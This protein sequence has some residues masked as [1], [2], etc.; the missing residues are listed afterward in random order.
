M[1][2]PLLE[3]KVVN[4]LKTPYYD[5]YIGRPSEWGNDH[6]IGWCKI[7]THS[8]DRNGAIMAFKR[9]FLFKL[10]NARFKLSLAELRGK[11]L[12]CHCAPLGCHGKVIA[13]WL[14]DPANSSHLDR[15]IEARKK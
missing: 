8:H 15:L 14:N 10:T 11:T 5:V 12:G 2:Q 13:N 6:P 3:T 1:N 4:V 7:C 9:D